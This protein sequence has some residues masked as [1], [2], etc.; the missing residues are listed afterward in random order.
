MQD[1]DDMWQNV[2]VDKYR[3]EKII[4]FQKRGVCIPEGASIQINT[5][6]LQR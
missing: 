3:I 1:I 2:T 4:S 6:Y 5:I